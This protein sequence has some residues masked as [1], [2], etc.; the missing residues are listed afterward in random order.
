MKKQK[1]IIADILALILSLIMIY[2]PL[3]TNKE[4]FSWI[5]YSYITAYFASIFSNTKDRKVLFFFIPLISLSFIRAY[6]IGFDPT[7]PRILLNNLSEIIASNYKIILHI[8]I[9]YLVERILTKVFGA[10]FTKICGIILFILYL[11]CFN[12]SY[13]KGL[14]PF[15][16]YM[17]FGF[18][19]FI[20]AR[21]NPSKKINPYLYIIAFLI[22]IIEIFIID[23]TKI[24]I[25]FSIG[26]LLLTYLILK[27]DIY[28]IGFEKYFLNSLLYLFVL[29]KFLLENLLYL[30]NLNLYISATI[31]SFFISIIFYQFRIKIFDYLF[32]GV[33]KDNA[34]IIK[35]KKRA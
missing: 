18:I 4:T 6:I 12:T 11:L 30:S 16:K 24:F 13:L 8:F 32:L 27:A 15:N 5:Y 20:F 3:F 19:Y 35:S 26:F 31:I 21:I 14:S 25:G 2:L 34:K 9:L 17:F 29:I 22:F 28:E 7:K 33:H 10:Y 1:L 23:K